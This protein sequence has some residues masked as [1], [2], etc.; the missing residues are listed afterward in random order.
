M[1]I[2][3]GSVSKCRHHVWKRSLKN[4]ERERVND[5]RR[6]QITRPTDPSGDDNTLEVF[7]AAGQKWSRA[8]YDSNR[9]V[10]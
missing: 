8:N 6:R 3:W 4:Y 5:G 2:D 7:G 10:C 1:E 9:W